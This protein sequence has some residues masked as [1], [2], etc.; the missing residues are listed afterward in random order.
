MDA[1]IAT[2]VQQCPECQEDRLLHHVCT[3]PIAAVAGAVTTLGTVVYTLC[4][5][6]FEAHVFDCGRCTLEMD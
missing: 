6:V 3:Q 2:Q 5:S 1:E 4:R